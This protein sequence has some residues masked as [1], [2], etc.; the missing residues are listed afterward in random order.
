MLNNTTLKQEATI[1]DLYHTR[2]GEKPEKVKMGE[3]NSK[4]RALSEAMHQVN[5][6]FSYNGL[7][8]AGQLIHDHK[9]NKLYIFIRNPHVLGTRALIHYDLKEKKVCNVT[10]GF[11][12]NSN[13]VI[14]ADC[15]GLYLM[16]IHYKGIIN[17]ETLQTDPEKALSDAGY[18]RPLNGD[19]YCV[20]PIAISPDESQLFIE[21]SDECIRI[22]SL[23]KSNNKL[24]LSL[25]ETI[26]SA[27]SFN[28]SLALTHTG[29]LLYWA[30]TNALVIHKPKAS[31]KSR[32][33]ECMLLSHYGYQ[34]TAFD[35]AQLKDPIRLPDDPATKQHIFFMNKKD[36]PLIEHFS[37]DAITLTPDNNKIRLFS[38]NELMELTAGFTLDQAHYLKYLETTLKDA[39]LKKENSW[40]KKLGYLL[41]LKHSNPILLKTFTPKHRATIDRYLYENTIGSSWYIAQKFFINWIAPFSSIIFGSNRAY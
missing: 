4:E 34:G 21:T 40:F 28:H 23:E 36:I 38:Y 33:A 9:R 39:Q 15:N 6:E 16:D 19:K 37:C 18:E 25:N 12:R 26:K 14:S 5:L 13:F 29:Y 31:S 8:G 3:K 27:K 17:L 20:G 11:S 22:S 2:R 7:F 10:E 1:L 35:I 32:K 41:M 30:R 24:T